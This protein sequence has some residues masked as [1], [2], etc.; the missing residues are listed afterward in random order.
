[1]KVTIHKCRNFSHPFPLFAWLI[2]I[3]QG[4]LPWKKSSWSHMAMS[5]NGRYYDCRFSGCFNSSEKEFRNTYKIL[6]SHSLP[7]Q[8]T[9]QQFEDFFNKYKHT[10]YDFLQLM[11]LALKYLRIVGFNKIGHDLD[12]MICTELIIVHLK[13]YYGFSF[14][15][16]DDFDLVDTWNIIKEY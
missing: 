1:M 15:D 8:L 7:L 3:F 2:M 12:K 9:Q 4:M 5:F 14:I 10:N 16:S 11:G 6:D 13:D